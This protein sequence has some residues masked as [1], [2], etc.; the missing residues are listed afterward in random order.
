MLSNKN[1]DYNAIQIDLPI[2]HD[3]YLDDVFT[4][5][6]KADRNIG[7][8]KLMLEEDE[9]DPR[10]LF[11]MARDMFYEN[12]PIEDIL[13]YANRALEIL[14]FE[15]KHLYH[16]EMLQIIVAQT[17]LNHERYLEFEQALQK[18]NKKYVEYY[19]LQLLYLHKSGFDKLSGS[20]AEIIAGLNEMK[21]SES[22]FNSNHDHI[23]FSLFWIY[24]QLFQFEEAKNVLGNMKYGKVE[25][26]SKVTELITQLE[27][28][29]AEQ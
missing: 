2:I 24:L 28:I 10:W 3:G 14:S 23:N 26:K 8:L 27:N 4:K 17:L 16:R 20:L 7:I 22:V 15:S 29:F 18:V 6:N 21:P 12:Y 1:K 11:F 19:Y 13:S 5:K 25:I 9:S